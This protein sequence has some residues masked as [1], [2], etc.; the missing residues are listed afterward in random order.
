MTYLLAISIG[1]VQEFISAARRTADLYAGSK[2][3]QD[4][5]QKVTQSLE[6]DFIFPSSQTAEGANKILIQVSKDPKAMVEQAK[7]VARE[8][9]Q[10]FWDSKITDLTP[11]QRAQVDETR[12]KEQFENFLEFYAAWVPVGQ[13]YPAARK[14]VDRLLAGRKALRD[15]EFT[16]QNDEGIPKSPLDPS[17]ASVLRDVSVFSETLETSN[18]RLRKTECLDAVSLLKRIYGTRE[19]DRV[20]NTR[21]MARLAQPPVAPLTTTLPPAGVMPLCSSRCMPSAEV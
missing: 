17:R 16:N 1:P 5:C 11:V 20:I 8:A 2:L 9:L 7:K 18:I 14:T 10:G 21:T 4:I 19:T 15:F 12:A 3:L 6:G 13:D